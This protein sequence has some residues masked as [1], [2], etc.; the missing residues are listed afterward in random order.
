MMNGG[1]AAVASD[2]DRR[3]QTAI[4]SP[5]LLVAGQLPWLQRRCR[6]LCIPNL[7]MN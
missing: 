1:I 7:L 2:A 4:F 6:R 5:E 3:S